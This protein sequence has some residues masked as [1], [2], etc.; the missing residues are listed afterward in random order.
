MTWLVRAQENWTG[1]YAVTIAAGNSP[2]T[3]ATVVLG[4][5]DAP[6]PAI[7]EGAAHSPIKELKEDYP[8]PAQEPVFLSHGFER[9]AG[10]THVAPWLLLYIVAYIPV[11]ALTRFAL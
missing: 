2:P 6:A 5:H 1:R 10:F 7:V 4:D 9:I 8:R 11:L 3:T